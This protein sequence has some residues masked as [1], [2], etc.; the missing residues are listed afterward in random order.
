MTTFKGINIKCMFYF[1][2]NLAQSHFL[3]ISESRAM[4]ISSE[5]HMFQLY[6]EK[7]FVPEQKV[8]NFQNNVL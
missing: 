6:Q 4:C 2:T 5:N 8:Y 7:P 3:K 1:K